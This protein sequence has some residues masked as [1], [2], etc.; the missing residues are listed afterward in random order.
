[1]RGL[2]QKIN[3]SLEH[4]GNYSI[5]NLIQS[6]EQYFQNEQYKRS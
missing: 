3:T 6:K 2:F 1:M 5:V 4:L